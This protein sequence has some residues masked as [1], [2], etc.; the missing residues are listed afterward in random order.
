M[1]FQKMGGKGWNIGAFSPI[2][3]NGVLDS[4]FGQS[5]VWHGDPNEKNA[6]TIF[7]E[8]NNGLQAVLWLMA[9]PQ[10]RQV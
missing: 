10:Q 4:T 3:K 2:V 6:R 7:M 5:S 8:F 1:M 9:T